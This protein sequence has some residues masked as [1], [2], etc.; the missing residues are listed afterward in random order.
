MSRLRPRIGKENESLRQ[1]RGRKG[2]KKGADVVGV[3]ADVAQSTLLDG[4]E[5]FDDTV[6]ERFT[7]DQADIRIGARLMDQVLSTAEAYLQ[8]DFGDGG[9][10][11]LGQG[12]LAECFEAQ[13]EARQC[14]FH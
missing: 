1:A 3:E 2:A 13:A 14:V 10:K 9:G 4:R 12:L 7:T 5:C 11:E 6:F 8:P